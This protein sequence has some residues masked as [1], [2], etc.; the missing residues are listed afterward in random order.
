[1]MLKQLIKE[2]TELRKPVR[3]F[4]LEGYAKIW[5]GSLCPWVEGARFVWT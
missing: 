5:E 2:Y 4:E 1:M 3:D